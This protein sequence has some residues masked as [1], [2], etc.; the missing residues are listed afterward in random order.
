[1]EFNRSR[2][3]QMIYDTAKEKGKKIGD[4]ETTAGYSVGYI[5]RLAKDEAKGAFTVDFLV[6]IAE[7]LGV[8]LD[9]LALTNDGQLTEDEMKMLSF[10]DGLIVD[11][12]RN[13]L[14]WELMDPRTQDES[15]LFNHALFRAR[16]DGY[17][18]DDNGRTHYYKYMQYE[19]RFFRPKEA[20]INGNCYIASIDDFSKTKLYLMSVSVRDRETYRQMKGYEIYFIKGNDVVTPIICSIMA[21]GQL[22]DIID[23]LYETVDSTR[24]KLNVTENAKD[25]MDRYMKKRQ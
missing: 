22:S 21:S 17:Y 18:E 10:L 24:L 9:F 14:R 4:I 15:F 20:R 6:A 23:R 5:S 19:S 12:E 3:I 1:M 11:T 8:S 2:M 25:V 13:L 16:D 7:Q